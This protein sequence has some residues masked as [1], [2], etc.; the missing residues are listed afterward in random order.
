MIGLLLLAG[1]GGSSPSTSTASSSAPASS[2]PGPAVPESEVPAITRADIEIFSSANASAYIVGHP[3]A[4][5]QA[6]QL[7]KPLIL[8]DTLQVKPSNQVAGGLLTSLL[9][10][11]D[12]LTPGLTTGTGDQER[13][14]GPIVHRLLLY[15]LKRP[16]QVFYPQA[17]QGVAQLE[18][19]LH[20]LKANTRVNSAGVI[21]PETA[22]ELLKREITDAGRYWP[23]LA[24]RLVRLASSLQ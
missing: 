5:Q 20:G 22:R 23:D 13:L 12:S 9:G 8:A 18:R 7:L 17:A 24:Q 15:G 11:L 19:L 1:C 4:V 2:S 16:S 14:N 10:Q 6:E 3:Q 21:P